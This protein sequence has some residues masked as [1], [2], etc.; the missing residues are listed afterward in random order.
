MNRNLT[1]IATYY[2]ATRW[3]TT[4]E[5]IRHYPGNLPLSVVQRQVDTLLTRQRQ[6]GEAVLPMTDIHLDRVA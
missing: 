6:R 1:W 4:Q 3:G 5:K 2:V